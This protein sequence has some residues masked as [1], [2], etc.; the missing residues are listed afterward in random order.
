[1][2]AHL[3][4]THLLYQQ[5]TANRNFQKE[6]THSKSFTPYPVVI[7]PRIK[8]DSSAEPITPLLYAGFLEHLGRCIYGG[9]VDNPKDPSPAKLLEKQPEGEAGWRTDVKE[10]LAAEGELAVQMMRW[11]GGESAVSSVRSF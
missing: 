4:L 9:I 5:Q 1:M 6:Y 7:D 2:A 11:P 3:S 8:A 10:L